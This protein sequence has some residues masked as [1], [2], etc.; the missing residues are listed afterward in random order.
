VPTL[1]A[2]LLVFAQ[3]QVPVVPP[4]E[5]IPTRLEQR[6]GGAV[7]VRFQG[8][9]GAIY[10]IYYS[11]SLADTPEQMAWALAA[12]DVVAADDW[13]E[14]VDVG[15]A[16]RAHP[17]AV[18]E[19]YYQVV[20]Q[21]RPAPAPGRDRNVAPTTAPGETTTP[22]AGEEID[23]AG[24]ARLARLKEAYDSGQLIGALATSNYTA[25]VNVLREHGV[26]EATLGLLTARLGQPTAR[27]A[28][29][30]E[31]F[32]AVVC[33]GERS[34]EREAVAATLGYQRTF[35]MSS[36]AG[37]P[38][39][40]GGRLGAFTINIREPNAIQ[41]FKWF[42]AHAE[43]LTGV[44]LN[45]GLVMNEVLKDGYGDV[46]TLLSGLHKLVKARQ[47]DAFVWAIVVQLPDGS[48]TRFLRALDFQPDGLLVGNLDSFRSPFERTLARL[49]PLVRP[50][51][52]L[53][54]FD[55]HGYWP[56]VYEANPVEFGRLTGPQ[57]PRLEK[58]LQAIGYRGLVCNYYLLEKIHQSQQ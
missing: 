37:P 56:Q 11:D 2:G 57:L 18:A 15:G 32:R 42:D 55:F 8:Q 6:A 16:G 53:V 52:P 49:P 19:R 33:H 35:W 44:V 20:L 5:E 4:T 27:V 41:Y 3:G 34:Q 26:S 22:T 36:E 7:A 10:Q 58:R 46:N 30:D 17:A 23:I 25:V 13:T 50:A 24:N 12:A 51:T 43:Q 31:F 29:P 21:A 45:W 39:W 38:A 28:L 1:G 40:A 47:P 9:P 54:A 14:W 48:D